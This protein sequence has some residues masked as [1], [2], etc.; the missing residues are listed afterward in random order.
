MWNVAEEA[1]QAAF[2]PTPVEEALA[3]CHKVLE[4][5]NGRPAHEAAVHQNRARLEAMRGN[6]EVARAGSSGPGGS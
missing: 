2:G 3:L 6:F 1:G 4:R 5:V